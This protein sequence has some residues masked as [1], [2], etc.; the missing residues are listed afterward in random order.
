MLKVIALVSGESLGLSLTLL[1]W[2]LLSTLLQSFIISNVL[3]GAKFYPK[4]GE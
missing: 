3:H 2:P 4:K 1:G